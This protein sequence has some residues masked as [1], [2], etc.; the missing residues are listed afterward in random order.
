[1][2][3]NV[4]ADFFKIFKD[5]FHN[6]FMRKYQD[7]SFRDTIF[8]DLVYFIR[9][10]LVVEITFATLDSNKN[11]I[12]NGYV[13]RFDYKSEKDVINQLPEIPESTSTD[14]L[15]ILTFNEEWKKKKDDEKENILLNLKLDWN[16]MP[17]IDEIE[18]NQESVFFQ[19]EPLKVFRNVIQAEIDL[20][21]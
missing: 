5:D 14:N 2:G 18:T 16:Y 7:E 11:M 15:L 12:K 9:N 13:F 19:H 10:E 6:F 20:F 8:N 21:V 17:D 1:M 3:V 4:T